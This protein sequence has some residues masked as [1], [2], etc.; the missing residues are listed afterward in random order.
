MR[1]TSATSEGFPMNAPY[2]A[3]Q[4]GSLLRPDELAAAR[5][6]WKTGELDGAGL[7][8]AEDRAIVE[9][10]RHQE[11]LGLESITDGEFRRDWWHL[12][13]LARLEGVT[14]QDNPGP[15]FRVAGL[16]EQPPIATV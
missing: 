12:D 9:A 3:D 1:D 16:G 10:V 7:K 14:L 11:A 8:Q 5:R 6:Q 2:R 4:V 13:F 15:K